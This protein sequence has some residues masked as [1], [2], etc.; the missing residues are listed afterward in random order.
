MLKC[1]YEIS[2]HDK[3]ESSGIQLMIFAEDNKHNNWTII[4]KI[5]VER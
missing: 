3:W 4:R 5:I 1:E 2:Q